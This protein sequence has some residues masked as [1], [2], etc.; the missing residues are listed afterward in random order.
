M[1]LS[2]LRTKASTRSRTS[3]AEMFCGDQPPDK[4]GSRR[5]VVCRRSALASGRRSVRVDILG[6]EGVKDTVDSAHRNIDRPHQLPRMRACAAF[7]VLVELGLDRVLAARQRQHAPNVRGLEGRVAAHSLFSDAAS[8]HIERLAQLAP[9]G[10]PDFVERETG[11]VRARKSR[12]KAV[13]GRTPGANIAAVGARAPHACGHAQAGRLALARLAEEVKA[14]ALEPADVKQRPSKRGRD[15]EAQK[16]M[17]FGKGADAI[18]PILKRSAIGIWTDGVLRQDHP[19][20]AGAVDNVARQRE[21]AG[22]ADVQPTVAM[23]DRHALFHVDG[24]E[25]FGEQSARDR[26][27]FDVH[28]PMSQAN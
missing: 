15:G 22:A 14:A 8:G 18:C 2:A 10:L 25:E 7:R 27:A 1:S 21:R 17:I 20:F 16:T 24:G 5:P 11:V 6:L 4:F 12:L 26:R 3:F 23:N 19:L 9:I 28:A 13:S